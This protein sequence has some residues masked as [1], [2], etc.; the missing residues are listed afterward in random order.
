MDLGFPLKKEEEK[1]QRKRGNF[2]F[3]FLRKTQNTVCNSQNCAYNGFSFR[4][5]RFF[6]ICGVT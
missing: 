4:L 5:A 2:F 1:E 3:F 6:S